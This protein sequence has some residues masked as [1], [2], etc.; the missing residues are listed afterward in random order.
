MLLIT[1]YPVILI[2]LYHFTFLCD[3][4]LIFGGLQ[5]VLDGIAS[6]EIYLYPIFTS[7]VLKALT[8]PFSVRHFYVYFVSFVFVRID[9]TIGVT[10]VVFGVVLNS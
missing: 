4:I 9:I 10:V 1:F 2:P 8:K 5:E 3:G 6:F 7:N